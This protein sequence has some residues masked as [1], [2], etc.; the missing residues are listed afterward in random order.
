MRNGK[1]IQQMRYALVKYP[2]YL[3]RRSDFCRVEKIVWSG[4]KPRRRSK[5]RL[6]A[7]GRLIEDRGGGLR[8][9]GIV[10]VVEGIDTELH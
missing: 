8:Q 9:G 7:R 5:I 6:D 1:K 3:V 10:V 4:F 2:G